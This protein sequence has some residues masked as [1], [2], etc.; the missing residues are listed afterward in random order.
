LVEAV[1]EEA[2]TV[3]LDPPGPG[4]PPFDPRLPLK[5][6]VYGYATGIR[7]SR[8]LEQLCAESLPFLYLTRGDTPGYRTLCRTRV[9]QSEL[10]EQVWI[11]LFTVASARGLKRLGH[12]VVDSTKLRAD[13]SP[14]AVVKAEEYKA[15]RAELAAILAEA[16]Q[17][18]AREEQEG[19]R[20]TTRL[21]Q[22]VER[23]QMRDIVRRVRKQLAQAKRAQK[24]AGAA[25]PKAQRR[26]ARRDTGEA[27]PPEEPAALAA[28]S[29]P[30]VPPAPPAGPRPRLTRRM[31]QRVKAGL[32]AVE[33]ALAEERK[34]LCLTD[35]DARMMGEGRSRQVRE[36][37]SFEVA[38]DREAGLLVVGQVTQ[39]AS[40]NA[41]LEPLVEAAKA[42]EPEGVKAVDG[43]S[44]FYKGGPLGRLIGAGID[45]C[46]PDSATAGDL[47]RGQ[48][49]GTVQA[50]TRGRVVFTYDP[51]ADCY[52]CPEGNELR[53]GK[54]RVEGGQKLVSYAAQRSCRGCPRESEC[55]LYPEAQYRTVT[56]GEFQAELD[57]ARE[58]FDEPEHRERYRHRGE[59]V[60]TVFG[61]VRGTLGYARW[62]LRGV[63]R[64][65]CEARLVKLAYQLRKVQV[66]RARG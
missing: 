49:V 16:E 35:P 12:I 60:E 31:R 5:V 48:P 8:R 11:S 32:A 25:A 59:V 44:G 18:D 38:V 21:G 30:A 13:A 54:S 39:E 56:V 15:L 64:V 17:V 33:A 9:E 58:R 1:V 36:G 40:D 7:S 42:H 53:R 3:P 45:T 2:I 29:A 24:A 37:Y 66:S 57:A 50:R 52:R 4:Q 62:L 27:A 20:G 51:E 28:G 22:A 10:V 14:E 46:V 19:P 6:L 63:E 34:H 55:L 43:D 65:G 26:S 23:E 61:F 47:H 41:R